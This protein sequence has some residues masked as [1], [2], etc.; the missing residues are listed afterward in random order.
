[1]GIFATGVAASV[2]LIAA[3]DR[4]FT[5][6]ICPSHSCRSCRSLPVCARNSRKYLECRTAIPGG[7][8]GDCFAVLA[9]ASGGAALPSGYRVTF[10]VPRSKAACG[11]VTHCRPKEISNTGR[12]VGG[13]TTIARKRL[14]CPGFRATILPVPP[15][16]EY[17]V[18]SPCAPRSHHVGSLRSGS[19]HAERHFRACADRP[20]SAPE[21]DVSGKSKM[22]ILDH[23]LQPSVSARLDDDTMEFIVRIRPSSERSYDE[24]SRLT[25]GPRSACPR[26]RQIFSERGV[27]ALSVRP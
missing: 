21:H 19:R 7:L 20:S 25:S 24:F 8:H 5:R 9:S 27:C 22:Q 16:A 23:L 14:I 18:S 1:M 2:L 26:F 10:T 15:S 3:H 13:R 12:C 11:L 4:P 17:D 6:Q